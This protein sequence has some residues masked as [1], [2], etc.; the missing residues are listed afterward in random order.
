MPYI[1]SV[2]RI[3]LREGRLQGLQEGELRGQRAMLRRL[4]QARF[5]LVPEALGRQIGAASS[6]DDLDSISSE[7]Q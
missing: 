6:P 2:E 7:P 4:V 1:T 3:G 5:G